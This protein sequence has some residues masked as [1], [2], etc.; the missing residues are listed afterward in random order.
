[1]HRWPPEPIT[2][3]TRVDKSNI[4][5]SIGDVATIHHA[6]AGHWIKNIPIYAS[7][8]ICCSCHYPSGKLDQSAVNYTGLEFRYVNKWRWT[9]TKQCRSCFSLL[10]HAVYL[11]FLI[12]YVEFVWL[13]T[14]ALVCCVGYIRYRILNGSTVNYTLVLSFIPGISWLANALVYGTCNVF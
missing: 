14:C 8:H 4:G 3:D 2:T 13:S 5:F 9:L 1:M 12:L 7:A 11:T 10:L 6:L